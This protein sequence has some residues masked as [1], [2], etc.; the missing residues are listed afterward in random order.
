[1]PPVACGPRPW[2]ARV[3]LLGPLLEAPSERGAIARSPSSSCAVPC[4]PCRASCPQIITLIATSFSTLEANQVGLRYDSVAVQVANDGTLFAAGVHFLGVGHWFI[5]YPTTQQSVKF[6]GSEAIQARTRNGLEVSLDVSFNFRLKR[7]LTDLVELYYDFGEME[8][9]AT[10]Y[11]RIARN[12]V[13][14]SASRYDAF[15]FFFNR[16]Q[17]ETEMTLSLRSQLDKTH[18]LLD[19]FQLLDVTLPSRFSEARVKQLNAVQEKE[20]AANEKRVAQISA[21]TRINQTSIEVEAIIITANKEAQQQRIAAAADINQLQRRTAA[22]AAGFRKIKDELNL[23]PVDTLG[24]VYVDA[25][26]EARSNGKPITMRVPAGKYK[27]FE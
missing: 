2:L 13:R 12:V 4:C 16:T 18:G 9:V 25:L 15:A 11:N 20:A 27:F 7:S 5:V 23:S 10:V 8:E 24:Y 17:V 3:G 14:T 22:E 6:Q 26:Q 21:D 1:M 19:S